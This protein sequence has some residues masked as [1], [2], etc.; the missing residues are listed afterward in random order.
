MNR[1][2]MLIDLAHAT[3][4]DVRAAVEV[5]TAPMII[6]HTNLENSSGWARFISREHARL[7]SQHGGVVGSMPI[8]LGAPGFHGFIENIARLVDTIGI[9]HVAIGTDMDGIFPARQATFDDYT[10]W[11]SI[12]AALLARGFGRQD[13]AKV[14]GGNFVRVFRAATSRGAA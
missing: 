6:S 5:S 14:I 12:P 1:L 9:D 13:V 3:L 8:A 7:F 2:G 4:A 11:P 10:E